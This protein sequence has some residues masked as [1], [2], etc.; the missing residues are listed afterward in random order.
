MI[1]QNVE[2]RWMQIV[3]F[4]FVV[5]FGFLTPAAFGTPLAQIDI[6][7]VTARTIANNP[8]SGMDEVASGLDVTPI[9]VKVYLQAEATTTTAIGGYTWSVAARPAGSVAQLSATTG[10][11]VIFRP[12]VT[13]DYSITLV[14]L[15]GTH[16]PTPAVSQLLH[17]GTWVG[18]GTI[19][20]HA[21]PAP[22][23]PQCGTTFCHG[24]SNADPDLNVLSQWQQS[25]HAHKLENH[26]NG[27]FGSHYATSCLQCHTLGF[28]SNPAAVNGGFDDV[29]KTIN[30]DLNLIPQLVAL[31]VQ[32]LQPEFPALP[33]ELQAKANIQCESCH[34][35]G[36]RHPSH[37]QDADHGIAGAD[38]DTKQCAQCHDSVSGS[39]QG[40]WQWSASTHPLANKVTSDIATSSNGACAKCHTGEGFVSQRI[41]GEAA[42]P[43]ANSHAITCSTCHDPH[44]SAN[45][46]QLRVVGDF[47]FDSGQTF[48]NPGLGG[49]CMRCHNSRVVSLATTLQSSRGPHHGP[50][51]DI[52]DGVNGYSFDLPFS[53]NSSHFTAVPDTC[54]HCH[55]ATP[56]QS[57]SGIITPAKVGGHTMSMRDES[58]NTTYSLNVINACDS[59]HAGL[60]TYDRPAR[61]DYDGNGKKEGIQT[62]VKGLMTI[63]RDN[64]LGKIAGTSIDSTGAIS[65]GSAAYAKLALGQQGAIYNYNLVSNDGSFGVHNASY[66]V[67]LLQR[68]Y[69]GVTGRPINKDYPKMV[70]RAPVQIPANAVRDWG[71]Y[72]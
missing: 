36:S 65:I 21:T 13:G 54:V 29:A 10:T 20:T 12:D 18:V 57:G 15:G 60:A 34:G 70:L 11:L 61:G 58:L 31:S 53:K 30:Y 55:M 2:M 46:H 59:C 1:R 9:G 43:I 48:V 16:L 44:Y 37:L 67:Q 42:A 63:L 17:A 14:P 27:V 25:L 32:T 6:L 7:S 56:N 49:L 19:N 4:L 35:P 50:Q 45:P 68:S 24:G 26:M 66:I 69:Y 71:A 47:T 41:N 39:Q 33:A 3:S 23:A 28:D 52:L 62:E 72:D 38:L 22:F 8:G 51:A 64:I 5:M 40:F